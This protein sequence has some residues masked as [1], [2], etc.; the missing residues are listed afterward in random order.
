MVGVI[1][2]LV[3]RNII[4]IFM[5][6]ELIL[7]AVNI[8]LVPW[9]TMWAI[10]RARC[11]RCHHAVA[12]AEAAVGLGILLAF[13][14]TKKQSRR[15]NDDHAVVMRRDV[16]KQIAAGKG[17]Q[18]FMDLICHP[19]TSR[20][21]AALNGLIGIRAFSKRTAGLVACSTMGGGAAPLGERV[22]PGCSAGGRRPLSSGHYRTL[23]PTDSAADGRRNGLVRG[24]VGVHA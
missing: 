12:A 19:D 15:R 6:I 11:L 7:N 21:R 2:V 20:H 9:P 8:N 10:C 1:G 18:T 13:I 22:R 17:R 24:A 3:R 14:A 4:I 23:D 16:T 5:S